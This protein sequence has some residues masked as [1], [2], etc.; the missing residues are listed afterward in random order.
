[1]KKAVL[2]LVAIGVLVG[3][4]LVGWELVAK[5]GPLRLAWWRYKAYRNPVYEARLQ[6][7]LRQ[8]ISDENLAEE[9][10]LLDGGEVLLP[11]IRELGLVE[12]WQLDGE[13]AAVERLASNSMLRRG[14]SELLLVLAVRDPNQELAGKIIQ[15]LGKSLYEQK[16]KEAREVPAGGGP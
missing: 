13:W 2:A 10:Q 14:E 5:P 12:T 1:M 7:D 6:M 8:A 4:V 9:N 3:A 16:Q 11:V 15:P